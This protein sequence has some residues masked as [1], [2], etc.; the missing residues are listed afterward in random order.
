MPSFHMQV[1]MG[2]FYFKALPSAEKDA[3]TFTIN[4]W[5]H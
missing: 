5:N 1:P 4:I 2:N 3:H